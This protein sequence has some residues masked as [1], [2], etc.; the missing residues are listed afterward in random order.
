MSRLLIPLLLL[1]SAVPRA[2]ADS[3]LFRSCLEAIGRQAVDTGL[4]PGRVETLL[5]QLEPQPRVLELDRA[6]P[7]FRQT[8]A[9]YM[10]TRVNERRIWQGR[11]ML[12][13]HAELLLRLQRE[14]GVP[15]RYLVAFWGMET[16]YG[17]FLGRMPTLD[18]LATL[19][20][21]ERRSEF[22]TAEL[23]Q[24]L[25]L[26]EREGLGSDQMRG[27][28]AGAMGHTQ[29]MPS[30]YLAHAIDGD[31][32]GR[33][34]LWN[35]I[36]DALSSAANFL[37]ELGWRPGARWGREVR[38]PEG[39]DY[40]LAAENGWRPLREWARLGIRNIDDGAL[41]I[42]DFEASLRVPMGHSGPAFLIYPN[43]EVIL[44][45]NRSENYAIAVGHL[46]DRIVGGPSI[47]HLPAEDRLPSGTALLAMQRA[48]AERGFDPGELDGVLGPATRAAL[49]EFQSAA[50]LVA[51]GYPDPETLTALAVST[52]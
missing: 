15:G 30:A 44:R 45:W 1:F 14:F 20:C 33:V 40:R 48:L 43:F 26:A 17:S 11:L 39:F 8:F 16:N 4:D 28:W 6:Q 9:G 49:R 12:A 42:A 24:A 21:D 25:T 29:F 2:N 13:Q 5:G 34:D 19:A 38:L 37:A 27:S 36:E 18:S 31:G 22:F 7:E 35:S 10:R 51:D 23:I 32:D 47:S 52:D 41:P 46:A 3:D 50:D